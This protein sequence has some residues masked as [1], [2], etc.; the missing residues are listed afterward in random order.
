[1]CLYDIIS[2]NK[3]GTILKQNSNI[4]NIISGALVVVAIGSFGYGYTKHLFPWQSEILPSCDNK[5][6]INILKSSSLSQS[7][8]L[9]S[10]TNSKI[11]FSF[12]EINETSSSNESKECTASL[13]IHQNGKKSL[14]SKPSFSITSEKRKTFNVQIHNFYGSYDDV[15]TQTIEDNNSSSLYLNPPIDTGANK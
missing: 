12:S 1:M 5:E 2:L 7:E 11:T 8:A 13:F 14:L 6:V 4:K 3:K 10:M 15:S 9:S